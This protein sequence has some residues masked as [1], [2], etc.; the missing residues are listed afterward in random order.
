MIYGYYHTNLISAFRE[1]VEDRSLI[2]FELR[3]QIPDL[4]CHIGNWHPRITAVPKNSS[5][6]FLF[7]FSKI[8]DFDE[9]MDIRNFI[10]AKR[11][12]VPISGT[13][14]FQI[15]ALDTSEIN[16]FTVGIPNIVT[17]SAEQSVISF[18]S[19]SHNPPTP[20][21]INQEVLDELVRKLL[22]P[23]ILSILTRPISGYG[24]VKEID[25]RFN[26]QIPIARV[27]TY[28]YELEKQE[29]LEVTVQGR[30]K[31]YKPTPEGK[32]YIHDT[33]NNLQLGFSH[34]IGI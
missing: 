25:S 20:K 15:G 31:I 1:P 7:D 21:V 4:I 13:Y 32:A 2:R 28:L 12:I 30:S 23:V 19:V 6:R 10:L 17:L 22:E 34:I 29:L 3:D 26:V 24:I 8:N 27:Y 16:A 18:S 5:L 33:L 11:K 9:L 14:A